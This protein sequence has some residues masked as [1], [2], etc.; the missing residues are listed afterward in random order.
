[1]ALPSKSPKGSAD[2]SSRTIG[3]GDVS[4]GGGDVSIG[5]GDVSGGD[6]DVSIGGGDVRPVYY[7]SQ[8]I[9]V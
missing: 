7:K 5:D 8:T 1:M 6:G 2:R 9:V 4:I 3:D